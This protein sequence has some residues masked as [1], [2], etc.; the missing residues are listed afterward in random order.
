MDY[1]SAFSTHDDDNEDAVAVAGTFLALNKIIVGL[2][3]GV[4]AFS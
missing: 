3:Q 4:C 1:A 2:R